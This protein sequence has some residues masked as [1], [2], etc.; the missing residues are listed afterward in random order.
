METRLSMPTQSSAAEARS[1]GRDQAEAPS[2]AGPAVRRRQPRR[3]AVTHERRASRQRRVPARSRG[4][5]SA[6]PRCGHRYGRGFTLVELVVVVALITVFAGLAVPSVVRQLRDRRVAEAARQV[7]TLYRQARLRAMGRGSA[8]LVRFDSG[9]FQVLEARMGS[10]NLACTQM[11]FSSC[12]GNDWLEAAQVAQVGGWSQGEGELSSISVTLANNAD[13][14]VGE[15][16]LCFTP[17]GSAFARES[18]DGSQPFE[19]LGRAY[20]AR[21]ESSTSA[22]TRHV[23]ILPNG[24]SRLTAAPSP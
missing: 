15:L 19:R 4:T 10:R 14:A 18:T 21:I 9:S 16:E 12:L 2:L 7:S 11:P 23:V 5:A 3:A 13:T 8:V 1:A 24:T 17:M 20:T 22:R 6:R